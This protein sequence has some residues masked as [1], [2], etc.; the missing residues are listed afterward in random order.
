MSCDCGWISC[1]NHEIILKKSHAEYPSLI[2][3]QKG[4]QMMYQNV[5]HTIKPPGQEPSCKYNYW[6]VIICVFF[7]QGI[8]KSLQLNGH[9][10][11]AC[12]GFACRQ[13]SMAVSQCWHDVGRM[14]HMSMWLL[15][16]PCIII[17]VQR[18]SSCRHACSWCLEYWG[19]SVQVHPNLCLQLKMCTTHLSIMILCKFSARRHC[20]PP[21]WVVLW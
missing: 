4:Y 5:W 12:W 15:N 16:W 17:C 8:I 19:G 6:Y 10:V 14:S 3:F 9:T 18:T 1:V 13:P 20:L 11:G 2:N 7:C 21:G